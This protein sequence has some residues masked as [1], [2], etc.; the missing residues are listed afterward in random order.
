MSGNGRKQLPVF[1]G[2][3]GRQQHGV[4]VLSPYTQYQSWLAE[5][6]GVLG[7]PVN[8]QY[9]FFQVDGYTPVQP[10]IGLS[11]EEIVAVLGDQ[12]TYLAEMPIHYGSKTDGF[13]TR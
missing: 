1:I 6:S 11:A 12:E 4:D 10:Q 5:T 2:A 7:C 13:S 9:C 3:N 8:C